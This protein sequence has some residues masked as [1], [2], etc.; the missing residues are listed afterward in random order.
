MTMMGAGADGGFK[1]LADLLAAV[2]DPKKAAEVMKKLDDGQR[3]MRKLQAKIAEK[4][5]ALDEATA[6][7]Q[8]REKAAKQAL[9]KSE[10]NKKQS[11]AA[12][13][14]LAADKELFGKQT[15]AFEMDRA[16]FDAVQKKAIAEMNEREQA[17]KVREKACGD[18][19][20]AVAKQEQL[21]MT[22]ERLLDQ[23]AGTKG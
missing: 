23:L 14:R 21:W 7:F 6:E 12:N 16:N 22:R 15:R 17:L 20:T 18:R 11:S 9:A 1:Q 5:N 10:D 3:A 8:D 19:E 4:Q 2:T 13:A